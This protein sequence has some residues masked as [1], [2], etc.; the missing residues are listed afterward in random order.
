MVLK[1]KSAALHNRNHSVGPEGFSLNGKSRFQ[2]PGHVV[3]SKDTT[4]TPFKGNFPKGH[5]GGARCRVKGIKGR[6]CG[7]SG[8]YVLNIHNSGFFGTPQTLVKPAVLNTGGMLELRLNKTLHGSYPCVWVKTN[9]APSSRLQ[10]LS[11]PTCPDTNTECV[12]SSTGCST[13]TTTGTCANGGC[14]KKAPVA[15]HEYDTYHQKLTSQ[16]VNPAPCQKPFPF[17]LN[18]TTCFKTYLTPQGFYPG[19]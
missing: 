6:S 10:A 4:R 1:Q 7:S 3:L 13:A 8:Q 11:R 15:L 5:G 17:F 16:C 2:G 9:T 18:N 14:S 19:C 12:L